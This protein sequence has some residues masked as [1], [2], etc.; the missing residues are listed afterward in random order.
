MGYRFIEGV[1]TA[2][3]CFEAWGDSLQEIFESSA[4]AVF[5]AMANPKT[6]NTAKEWEIEISE[7]SAEDLLHSFLEEIIY[8]KDRE[9]AVF[10]GA[11]INVDYKK[12][13]VA[14]TLQGDRA[15]P[16]KQELHQD[17][18]AVTM[19]YYKLEQTEDGWKTQVVLD[20]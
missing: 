15:D 18:K 14:A 12:L 5:E 7:E 20:I 19:H 10:S 4:T 2:D 11:T 8:I 1:T 17:V 3:L 16:E 9:C 6:V 13:K